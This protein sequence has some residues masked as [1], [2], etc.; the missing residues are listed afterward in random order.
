MQARM[1]P[2]DVAWDQAE[3]TPDNWLAHFLRHDILR[4][5]GKFMLDHNG[6]IRTEFAILKKGSYNISLRLKDEGVASI[7]RLSQPGAIFSPEE[8]V[9]NEVAVI[10]FLTDKR[11][12]PI[13]FVQISVPKEESP[14]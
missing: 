5:I 9:A 13:P 1:S 10:R 3:E 11:S 2:D 6:G 7:I 4:P 12:I 14:L 8:K